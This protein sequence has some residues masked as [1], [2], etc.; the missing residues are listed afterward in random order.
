MSTL[1]FSV[2]VLNTEPMLSCTIQYD[3]DLL[4]SIQVLAGVRI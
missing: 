1:P 4:L 2:R 3:M